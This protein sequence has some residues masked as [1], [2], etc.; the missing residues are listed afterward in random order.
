[1]DQSATPVYR[2]PT[3][4]G[5]L[6]RASSRPALPG[7]SRP[8]IS[9]AKRLAMVSLSPPLSHY[10]LVAHVLAGALAMPLPGAERAAGES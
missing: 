7:E 6:R 5:Y 9:S 2:F 3:R 1:M 4:A 10:A 8:P